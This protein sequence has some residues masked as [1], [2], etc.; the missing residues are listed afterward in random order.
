MFKHQTPSAALSLQALVCLSECAGPYPVWRAD[1]LNCRTGPDTKH[2]IKK[3]YKEGDS[4]KI[5]CQVNGESV[6]GYKIWDKTQDGCYVSDYYVK[7][8]K[9]GFVA[10][11]CTTSK[12]KPKPDA[13]NNKLPG[14]LKDDY[15]YRGNCGGLDPWKYYKCQCTSF[16]AWR[17]NERLGVKFHNYYKGPHWGDAKIWDEAARSSGVK[18]DNNAVPGSI[19]QT[20]AGAGHVAWVTKVSGGKVTIE[21]YNGNNPEKYGRRTVDKDSFK[22]IHIKV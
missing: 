14:P 7:T 15:P 12:P 6:E 10:D 1:T 18:I 4:I 9:D 16:V 3:T 20:N 17:I 19:A 5:S 11:K 22:Y 2:G 13:E 21:E 8:G